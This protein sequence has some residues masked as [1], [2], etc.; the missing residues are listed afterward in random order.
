MFDRGINKEE[1]NKSLKVIQ[2]NVKAV[3]EEQ[4]KEVIT[5][6]S[7]LKNDFIE[8]HEDY[9]KTLEENLILKA[10]VKELE[11]LNR[12]NSEKTVDKYS[13]LANKL[14]DS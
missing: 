5:K 1:L 11:T 12:K 6:Y 4:Y 3:L 2:D 13:D 8:L 9:T 7:T 10:K 14:F